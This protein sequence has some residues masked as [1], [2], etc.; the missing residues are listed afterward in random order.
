[1][2]RDL[3]IRI[4]LFGN[5]LP[6]LRNDRHIHRAMVASFARR[7]GIAR[8]VHPRLGIGQAR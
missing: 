5:R 1:M 3:F 6:L 4:F 8:N 2:G 7:S